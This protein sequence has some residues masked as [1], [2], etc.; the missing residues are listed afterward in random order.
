MFPGIVN[1]SRQ[2]QIKRKT[3]RC[4][5]LVLRK[6]SPWGGRR[7]TERETDKTGREAE[8]NREKQKLNMMVKAHV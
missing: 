3:L 4:L 5:E 7:E 8:G 6:M 2:L 1:S